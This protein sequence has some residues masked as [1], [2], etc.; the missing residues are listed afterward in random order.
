[1]LESS[2][3]IANALRGTSGNIDIFA[4]HVI[5]SLDSDIRASTD[6]RIFGTPVETPAAGLLS[7]GFL[8][9][10]RLLTTPC[11]ARGGYRSNSLIAGGRGG[12]PPDPSTPLTAGLFEQSEGQRTADAPPPT[13][14]SRSPQAAKPG[15]AANPNFPLFGR[16]SC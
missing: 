8:D 3:I 13:T 1:V 6:L 2:H 15:V 4:D 14:T 11:A 12:L 7:V 9:A 16:P 5:R 10:P